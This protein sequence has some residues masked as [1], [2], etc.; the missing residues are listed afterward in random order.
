MNQ[1]KYETHLHTVQGSACG[2]LTGAE[3]ARIF[4]NGGYTGIVITDHF[5]GGNTAIDRSLPWEQWVE[6]FCKGYESAKA[7]G[8]RIGL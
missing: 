8:D 5:F 1:Y 2:W 4:K 3:M 7:E 6:Q